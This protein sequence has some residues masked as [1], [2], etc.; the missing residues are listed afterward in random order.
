MLPLP[1]LPLPTPQGLTPFRI[2]VAEQQG[3]VLHTLLQA[4]M[5]GEPAEADQDLPQQVGCSSSSSS[6]RSSV[7]GMCIVGCSLCITC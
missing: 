4:L 6:R 7:G 2:A 1:A 5:W 3:D